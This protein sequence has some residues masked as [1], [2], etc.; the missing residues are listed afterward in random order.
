MDKAYTKRYET[1][2]SIGWNG[3]VK[4]LADILLPTNFKI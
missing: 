1:L 3:L 4:V 2:I